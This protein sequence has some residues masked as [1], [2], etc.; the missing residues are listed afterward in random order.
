MA[1]S[2]FLTE[3]KWRGLL[4]GEL[5]AGVEAH[6]AT[7]KRTGY[8]GFDPTAASMTIGN[9]VQ[10]MLLT[11]FQRA[12][13]QP[14]FLVG[15]AT[16]RVGD[17]SGKNTERNML[18]FATLDA[19]VAKFELQARKFIQFEAVENRAV[20]VNNLHFYE[21]MNV[22]DFLRDVGKNITVNYMMAK[23][24]V[25]NRLDGT[26]DGLSFTEFS[27]QLLQGYDFNALFQAQ[28]CTVQ[29]GGSDQ[30]GNITTG[31]MLTR[32]ISGGT[33]FAVTTPLLTKSD[34]TKFGK[35]EKG[36]IW[37]DPTMT[38]PFEFYQFWINATD[39]DVPKFFR[40]FSLKSR[41]EIEAIETEDIRNQK[42]LLAEEITRR[43][44][45]DEDF[46]RVLR[47]SQLLFDQKMSPETLRSMDLATIKAVQKEIS[48]PNLDFSEIE[49]GIGIVDFLVKTNVCQSNTD[50]RN[51]LKGNAI[52]INKTKISDANF[53]LT[54][55]D[56]LHNAFLFVENGKKNK[57]LIHF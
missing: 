35:S 44:H 52:S 12:G 15:G 21:N 10:V 51:S 5:M 57:F 39:A 26:G 37:L 8:I 6:L 25:K 45:S 32:K 41:A 50:A 4:H 38:T 14:V 36:N 27:Y 46:E 1:F 31:T 28:N 9:Y 47:V 34:G 23:D 22:L 19:N 55:N 30:F 53:Q 33:V 54:K 24:S 3:M 48:S 49:N 13:H 18:D 40:Y 2:D 42:L 56:L 11:F 20:L 16:G 17:P 7:E 29:M 43:I